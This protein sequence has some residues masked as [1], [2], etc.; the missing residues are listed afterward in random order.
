MNGW[1][2]TRAPKQSAL[3]QSK[4]HQTMTT[5]P[6]ITPVPMETLARLAEVAKD[7]GSAGPQSIDGQ[8]G[9]GCPLASPASRSS[10]LIARRPNL[11]SRT[12]N[13]ARKALTASTL[14]CG[15]SVTT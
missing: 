13:A 5:T 15:L 9:R 10:T 4:G 3:A 7:C 11:R 14:G 1:P 6:E 12:F 8:E 2:L